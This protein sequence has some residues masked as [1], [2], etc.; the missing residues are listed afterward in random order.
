MRN[1]EDVSF[2]ELAVEMK[3]VTAA[4][5]EEAFEIQRKMALL[6]VYPKSVA[7]ILMDRG[8]LSQYLVRTLYRV[9]G[10]REGFPTIAGYEI[11]SKIGHGGMGTVYR[12]RQ[13]ELDRQVAIKVL[14]PELARDRSFVNRFVQ[15]ARAVARLNHENVIVGIDVG[16][17]PEGFYY[18][19][20]EY[21]EGESVYEI[22][23][24]EHHLPES[25]TLD[26]VLQMSR[27]LQHAAD[28]NLVHRDI[29][30][31]NIMITAEEVAKLCDLG[32][33]KSI[34]GK[35]RL[36][37]A[38]STHGT[39][40]YMSPEQA[41]G[42]KDIDIRSDIYSLG[43][44]M[45]HMLVGQVPFDGESAAVILL[46][47]ISE[48]VPSPRVLRPE[49]SENTCH[50]L[51]RMMAKKRQDRYQSP[52]E[53]SEDLRAVLAGGAPKSRR[54][55]P[56]ASSILRIPSDLI[57]APTPP[58][59]FREEPTE[60]M[61]RSSLTG[62][63]YLRPAVFLAGL[64]FFLVVASGL[65]SGLV[66][67]GDAP[68]PP[69]SPEPAPAP[70]PPAGRDR[71]P[72]SATAEEEAW[73]KLHFTYAVDYAI[74]HPE[75]PGGILERYLSTLRK[76]PGTLYA[77]RA[78]REI[79]DLLEDVE[80]RAGE[81][82]ETVRRLVLQ[83]IE[84]GRFPAAS[85]LVDKEREK[86]SFLEDPLADRV[87]TLGKLR[88]LE[89]EVGR[90][91]R[92]EAARVFAEAEGLVKEGRIGAAIQIL[93]GVRTFGLADV[94]EKARDTIASLE[95]RLSR[96]EEIE[97]RR[98]EK[99]GRRA[100][101]EFLARFQE[102]L[103]ARDYASALHACQAFLEA[104]ALPAYR[105]RVERLM[106]LAEEARSIWHRAVEA[107][108]DLAS[109]KTEVILEMRDG[110]RARGYVGWGEGKKTV[111]IYLSPARQQ[112]RFTIP[113]D[114]LASEEVLELAGLFRGG[115]LEPE[116]HRSRGRFLLGEGAIRA[117]SEAMNL[118]G[119]RSH[120]DVLWT[121]LEDMKRAAA[122]QE[123]ARIF[124]QARE[125]LRSAEWEAARGRL[126]ELVARGKNTLFLE[127][128][129]SAV[130][131]E[132]DRVESILA[133]KRNF[134]S[135][136]EAEVERLPR[137][138]ARFAYDFRDAFHYQDWTAAGPNEA[139][140]SWRVLPAGGVRASGRRGLLWI[141]RFTGEVRVTLDL[142]VE[143]EGPFTD[144]LRLA[145]GSE[146]ILVRLALVGASH[147]ILRET[148]S[149]EGKRTSVNLAPAAPSGLA[150]GARET[151]SVRAGPAGLTLTV[152]EG[153]PIRVASDATGPGR[154]SLWG[155]PVPVSYFGVRIE[156]NLDPEWVL[157]DNH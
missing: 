123:A 15:E 30:P 119:A 114:R 63:G 128:R 105:P 68:A 109:R 72:S 11:E 130:Q 145:Y 135:L 50:I 131:A 53:L 81:R 26:I 148:T 14:D 64:I 36:T 112:V 129:R 18:F 20:M 147:Q 120:P 153:T 34:R 9:Q 99:A 111:R 113:V 40:H 31:D 76:Y 117:A 102:F 13:T 69:P 49:I 24:V 56:G 103:G 141:A 78:D 90:R 74:A 37:Q 107:L 67:N 8:A 43:A 12:A 3:Y 33:A 29:K 92:E 44:T 149:P 16:K 84:A 87:P 46:K 142:R 85:R 83:H 122:E 39:P 62:A 5:A 47:H 124:A 144:V 51:E 22:L 58:D 71:T 61:A 137:G 93:E 28:H 48:E 88:D 54:L 2:A 95:D 121:I 108:S 25:R 38:G 97:R 155:T 77:F 143:G 126:E 19:V 154:V 101:L 66:R 23:K 75:D 136:L 140:P 91:A 151:V 41:R 80:T 79:R 115:R 156:C 138:R 100:Y 1:P 146:S 27:A 35:L 17:T 96:E 21:V 42:T 65:V 32:L 45:Y 59:A 7:E 10:R 134:A 89:A 6:G 139:E 157:A 86:I 4:Q 110:A 150:A 52:A 127:D 57:T 73:A 104:E 70:S 94:E 132:L 55:S 82:F 106:G 60:P 118:G 133:R 116:E 98:K 125:A 152:G